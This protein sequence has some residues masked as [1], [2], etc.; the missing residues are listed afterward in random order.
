MS[1]AM[2]NS[3]TTTAV[4]AATETS[5]QEGMSR[6]MAQY[7]LTGQQIPLIQNSACTTDRDAK[8]CSAATRILSKNGVRVIRDVIINQQGP[9]PQPYA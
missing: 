9:R 1:D 5:T 7:V 6:E 2:A 3:A 4:A 8:K